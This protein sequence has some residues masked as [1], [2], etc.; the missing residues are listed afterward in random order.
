MNP[1]EWPDLPP[2]YSLK[3]CASDAFATAC[4]AAQAGAAYREGGF[5]I[6]DTPTTTPTDSAAL[7]RLAATLA[8]LELEAVFVT[9]PDRTSVV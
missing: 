5:V 9:L 6:I 7:E 8:P 1:A 2:G 4:Q 3:L